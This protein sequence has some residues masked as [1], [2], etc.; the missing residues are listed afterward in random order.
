MQSRILRMVS[1]LAL[2][3]ILCGSKLGVSLV[4]GETPTAP[5]PT[6]DAAR[7]A[8]ERVL[9][10]YT[11]LYAGP[12]L[13][14]WKTLFHPSLTVASP[15]KD[16]AILVRT[17]DQLYGAQKARFVSGRNIGE[18]LENVRIEMGRRIACVTADFIFRDEGEERSGK[19]GL[20]LAEGTDGWRIVSIVF[21]Y[22]RA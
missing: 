14:R 6:S 3:C 5:G 19:L 15:G 10:D 18:R 17:L 9:A 22:D 13:E 4:A 8:V 11:G 20:H 1:L 21:A 12:T 16:G 7:I 2:S